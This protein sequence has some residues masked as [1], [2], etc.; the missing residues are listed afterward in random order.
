LFGRKEIESFY[1]WKIREVFVE[2]VKNKRRRKINKF[3]KDVER[4][5]R[6]RK[7]AVSKM[8]GL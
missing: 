1:F 6:F 4:L 7:R 2:S 5:A 8:A 3:V